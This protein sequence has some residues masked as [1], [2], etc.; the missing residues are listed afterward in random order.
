[1]KSEVIVQRVMLPIIIILVVISFIFIGFELGKHYSARNIVTQAVAS[2][3]PFMYCDI[4]HSL[5]VTRADIENLEDYAVELYII[6]SVRSVEDN[7]Q[8]QSG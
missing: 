7:K 4:H 3:D 6:M 8:V 2:I 5:N 1:M